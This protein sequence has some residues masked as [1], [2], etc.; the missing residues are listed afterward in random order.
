[1]HGIEREKNEEFKKYLKKHTHTLE[2]TQCKRAI[3]N[4]PKHFSSKKTE[5][6]A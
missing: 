1:M 2:C 4:F 3:E 6:R 5:K